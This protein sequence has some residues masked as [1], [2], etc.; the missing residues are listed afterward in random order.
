MHNHVVTKAQSGHGLS[1][2]SLPFRCC[3]LSRRRT[4]PA[5]PAAPPAAASAA[6]VALSLQLRQR[7]LQQPARCPG[8]R[9]R[10]RKA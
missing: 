2:L 4:L 6:A 9:E 7:L 8:L 10:E 3:S 5:T 1:L